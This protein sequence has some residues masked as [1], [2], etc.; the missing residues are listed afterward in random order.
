MQ[1][2]LLICALGIAAGALAEA[3]GIGLRVGYFKGSSFG[4]N[5]PGSS[6]SLEGF[7]AGIDYS[8]YKLPM[9]LAEIRISPTIT[10]GGSNRKGPDADGTLFR[11]LANVKFSVPGAPFYGIAGIGYG[12]ARPRGGAAFDS[13]SGVYS[14]LGMGF[15]LGPK[16]PI[17]P[18]PFVEIAYAFGDRALT[19]LSF[20]VGIRF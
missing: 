8:L 17:A 14:Q 9:G 4:G 20:D 2:R 7:E 12:S 11:F 16:L 3:Q 5:F 18:Q 15:D 10:F 1:T 19:G 6:I 13:R